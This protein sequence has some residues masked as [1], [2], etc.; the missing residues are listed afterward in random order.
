MRSAKNTGFSLKNA[1][2][3]IMLETAPS[4]SV[5]QATGIPSSNRRLLNILEG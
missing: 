4:I 2:C 1:A 3:A 5:S